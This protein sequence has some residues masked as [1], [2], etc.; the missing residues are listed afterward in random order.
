MGVDAEKEAREVRLVVRVVGPA[1]RVTY[2]RIEEVETVGKATK[3][4]N[5]E[6]AWAVADRYMAEHNVICSVI[7]ADDEERR[8]GD[9]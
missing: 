6:T 5:S 2:L 7:D 8:I 3:M 4:Q 9:V 1:G